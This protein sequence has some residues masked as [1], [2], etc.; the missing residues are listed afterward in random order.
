MFGVCVCVWCLRD[1]VAPGGTLDKVYKLLPLLAN[2]RERR[3]IALDGKL[4]HED[5]NLA[6]SSMW[7]D[8]RTLRQLAQIKEDLLEHLFLFFQYQGGCAEG[9]DGDHGFIQG[10]GEAHRWRVSHMSVCLWWQG[11]SKLSADSASALRRFTLSFNFVFI[12]LETILLFVFCLGTV[13]ASFS[14]KNLFKSSEHYLLSSKQQTHSWRRAG[15]HCYLVAKETD[16]YLRT[17]LLHVHI[18]TKNVFCS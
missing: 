18:L 9:S 13:V 2:N 10:H 5:T 4:K 8:S 3:G 17:T 12:C 6:S 1:S 7:A 14:E 11:Y 16:T 15:E